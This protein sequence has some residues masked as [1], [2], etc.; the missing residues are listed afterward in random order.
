VHGERVLLGYYLLRRPLA[1]LRE[2]S[3]W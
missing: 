2:W 1:T 3:G